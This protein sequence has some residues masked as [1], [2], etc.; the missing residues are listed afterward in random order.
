MAE[1]K[2]RKKRKRE[3]ALEDVGLVEGTQQN[4][5]NLHSLD[6]YGKTKYFIKAVRDRRLHNVE[7][8]NKMIT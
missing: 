5:S 1:A 3:N 2:K 6:I 8:V 7:I 4:L